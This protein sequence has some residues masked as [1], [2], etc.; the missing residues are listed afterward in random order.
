MGAFA[1]VRRKIRSSRTSISD[2]RLIHA[3]QPAIEP[4]ENRLL[5]ATVYVDAQRDHRH[6]TTAVHGP[7]PTRT[8]SRRSQP[9]PPAAPPSAVAAGTYK[10][11]SG[12]RPHRLLP[13]QER[14]RT[15][16]RLRGVMPIPPIQTPRD[17]TLYPTV[18]SGNIGAIGNN[19]DN[20]YHV[21]VG[22][23]TDSTAVLD[24]FTITAGNASGSNTATTQGAGLYNSSG[25]PHDPKLH[26]QRQLSR[27]KFRRG[28]RRLQ[29]R[30][31]FGHHQLHV[32]RE[33][34]DRFRRRR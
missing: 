24:G 33:L 2:K 28:R 9:P 22:S 7:T 25:S 6:P 1:F 21:V 5:L 29:L 31:F 10:P 20:S 15:R 14:C 23:G 27:R 32:Q 19:T 26:L 34:R 16:W 30:F 11:T 8:S 12:H 18:L 4:L 17:I 3:I 13:T